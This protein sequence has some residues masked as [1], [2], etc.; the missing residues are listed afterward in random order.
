VPGGN[1]RSMYPAPT[2]A[3]DQGS[4]LRLMVARN[5]KQDFGSS[6]QEETGYPCPPVTHTTSHGTHT[7]TLEQ[8]GLTLTR[9]KIDC[10][11]TASASIS[12]L[13]QRTHMRP[14]VRRPTH[15][16]GPM[17][18]KTASRKALHEVILAHPDPGLT[19]WI[20]T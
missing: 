11:F 16:G 8:F 9:S 7:D 19:N 15:P 6:S 12:P 14:Q 20:G 4:E 3:T 17:T 2:M 13:N 10:H 18:I 1:Q 5:C